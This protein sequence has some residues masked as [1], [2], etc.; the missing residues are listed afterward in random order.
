ASVI[1]QTYSRWELV[2]VDDGSTDGTP[3][4]V[5]SFADDRLR[6]LVHPHTGNI[7]RLRNLGAAAGSGELIAFLDSDDLWLPRK[8]ELQIAAL[9][10][11]GAAWCYS[12]F[13]MIDANGRAIPMR[14]GKF[15][16]LS[17][18]VVRTLLNTDM[19]IPVQTVMV[20]RDFFE[21]VGGFNEDPRLT[22]RED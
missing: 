4:R 1:E 11:S 2:V 19:S 6:I 15:Q 13:E 5:A 16:P 20:R 21:T 14:A 7:G 8:L 12:Q 3:N 22:T 17:G 9:R 10:N 18:R